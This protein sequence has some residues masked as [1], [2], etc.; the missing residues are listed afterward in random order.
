VKPR[1]GIWLLTLGLLANVMPLLTAQE[2]RVSSSGIGKSEIEALIV[3]PLVHDYGPFELHAESLQQVP[4]VMEFTFPEDLWL[5][6]YEIGLIDR[7]GNPLPREFQCHTFL[8]TSMPAHHSHEEV[9]G[10]FSDGYT[11]KLNLPSGFGIFFRAGEKIIWNPM[12]N[13]RNSQRAVASMRLTLDTVRARNLGGLKLKALNT[14]FRTIQDPTDLYFVSPGKDIR[15]TTF[16]LPF[17]GKIHVIGTHIHPFGISIELVNLTRNES[18]WLA[19]GERDR[20]DRLVSMPVYSSREG[21]SV[22][23]EDNFKLVAIYQNPTQQP[24]DA[25]AGVFI[26]YS[27]R[28]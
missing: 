14:T 10:I 22:K 19:V 21:Y 9:T 1:Y 24:V 12:F 18:V 15:E 25:M 3:E 4:P 2:S 17:N 20:N 6:G 28:P 27:T 16:K 5:V 7:A 13:N 8:G 23:S 11:S 26:L